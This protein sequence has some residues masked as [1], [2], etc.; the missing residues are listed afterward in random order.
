MAWAA[1][2]QRLVPGVWAG[3]LWCIAL[4]AT[5]APFAT[6]AA[7][8][9]G[10]VVARIFAPEAYLSLALGV[11]LVLLER[12]ASSRPEGGS[13]LTTTMLLS[14]VAIF[15]TVGGYFGLQPLMADA[16]AGQGSLSFG[17][18]HGLSLGLFGVK[19]LAVSALAWRASAAVS[20]AGPS[21]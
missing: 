13:R 16:R 12:R 4:I 20:S 19:M 18:L 6:L 3:V 15:C 7:H 11:A 2:A 8:D 17:Q 1:R 14:L 21:S 5:P 9:A 10:R